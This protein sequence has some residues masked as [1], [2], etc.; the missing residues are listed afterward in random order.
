MATITKYRFVQK[1]GVDLCGDVYVDCSCQCT[2]IVGEKTI[3]ISD[4]C[5]VVTTYTNILE[6]E[7]KDALGNVDRYLID[8]TLVAFKAICNTGGGGG[9]GLTGCDAVDDIFTTQNHTKAITSIAV[10]V[11]G[12]SA[13]CSRRVQKLMPRTEVFS[14]LTAGQIPILTGKP[15]PNTIKNADRN[16]GMAH[17]GL[18][19]TINYTTKAITPIPDWDNSGGGAG[20]ETFTITYYEAVL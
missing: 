9:G 10:L 16:T 20:G 19:Y 18:N 2:G 3:S 4:D 14:N 12:G 13:P 15:I 1:N 6:V 11:T 8:T 5:G 17:E 7:I